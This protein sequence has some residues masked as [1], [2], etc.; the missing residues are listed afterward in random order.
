MSAKFRFIKGPWKAETHRTKDGKDI[1]I[2]INGK[3]E[4][5]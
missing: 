5:K 3:D 1:N 4:T 2:P